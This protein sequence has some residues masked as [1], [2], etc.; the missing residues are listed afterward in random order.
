[1]CPVIFLTRFDR[2]LFRAAH[3]SRHFEVA[4]VGRGVAH[5]CMQP[6]RPKFVRPGV[7]SGATLLVRCSR[8]GARH[9]GVDPGAGR[10]RRPPP[11]HGL[12]ARARRQLRA[13]GVA[14]AKLWIV[15][16][17]M[18]GA[19]SLVHEPVC[20]P[21]YPSL[22]LASTHTSDES[23]CPRDPRAAPRRPSHTGAAAGRP[24]RHRPPRRAATRRRAGARRRRRRGERRCGH[25]NTR[26]FSS[27]RASR[28]TRPT[29]RPPRSDPHSTHGLARHVTPHSRAPRTRPTPPPLAQ[30]Q[31]PGPRPPPLP[32][33]A[34]RW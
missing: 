33:R 8:A 23:V 11:A 29:A 28:P 22:Y 17:H 10:A 7:H 21:F 31:A 32:H 34:E 19:T 13:A 6:R 5:A 1:M 18:P 26:F 27:T 30:A 14:C 3:V 20:A 16:V 4:C 9:G 2:T 15:P 24:R 12:L 25:A